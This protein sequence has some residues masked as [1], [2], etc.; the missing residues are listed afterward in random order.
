MLFCKKNLNPTFNF[1]IT[2][3]DHSKPRRIFI[4]A[5]EVVN[6]DGSVENYAHGDEQL[7]APRRA[8][9][10]ARVKTAALSLCSYHQDKLMAAFASFKERSLSGCPKEPE[11]AV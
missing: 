11:F 9:A 8:E 10:L 3:V 1:P 2:L 5:G 6:C 4:P 7:A